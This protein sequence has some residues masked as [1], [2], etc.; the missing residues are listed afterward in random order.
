MDLF[1][2]DLMYEFHAK[3]L[4]QTEALKQYA[5]HA[6]KEIK[7]TYGWDTDVQ[8]NIE[9]EA[10]NKHLFS[11]SMSVLGLGE[12]VV[13]KKDGKQVMS[14]LRK[15]RKAVMRQIRR[16]T[17]KRVSDRRKVILKEQIAS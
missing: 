1:S 4:T 11:V 8:I 12:P 6:V 3:E 10:K 14:I 5:D 13:V 7:T 2:Q 9:P 16:L 15:V 17:E